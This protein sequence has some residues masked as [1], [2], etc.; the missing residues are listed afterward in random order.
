VSLFFCANIPSQNFLGEGYLV[1]DLE[2]LS[3]PDDDAGWWSG[4]ITHVDLDALFADILKEVPKTFVGK[5]VAPLGTDEGEPEVWM[6]QNEPPIT[7]WTAL[8]LRALDTGTRWL[9]LL[10]GLLTR[11]LL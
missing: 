1:D 11:V 4:D 2:M 6:E 7:G 9:L 8:A 3:P 5:P 10:T